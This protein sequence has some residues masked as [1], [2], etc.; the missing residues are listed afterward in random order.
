MRYLS[1]MIL[2]VTL[3]GCQGQFVQ[4]I[5][6]SDVSQTILIYGAQLKY[7]K[8]LY[9]A[10]SIIYYDD[11]IQ[12]F[13]LDFTTQRIHDDL[14]SSRELLVDTVEGF[15][16][17]ING[18]WAIVPFLEHYPITADDLEVYITYTSFYTKFVDL[19]GD[20]LATLRNGNASYFT[21]TT[22]ECSQQCWQ[23]RREYYWQS[24]MFVDYNRQGEALYG[25]KP[26]PLETVFGIERYIPA[27][28]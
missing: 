1:F 15:L 2:L 22:F 7:E 14:W 10:D 17:R 11:T 26:N 8:G 9:L 6:S 12:R 18:N 13:R 25:P 23:E 5:D 27:S 19:Q 3:A 16:N 20:A 24:K 4:K 21:Y 28:K